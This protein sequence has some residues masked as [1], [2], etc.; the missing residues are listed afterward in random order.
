[1]MRTLSTRLTLVLGVLLALMSVVCVIVTVHAMNRHM[2]AVDQALHR[3]LAG[4]VLRAHLPEIRASLATGQEMP[5]FRQ[6]MTINPNAEFYLLDAGGRVMS[7]IVPEGRKV[8]ERVA[9]APIVQLLSGMPL[10]ILGED[11][12]EPRSRRVF[13]AAAVEY[14]GIGAGYVYVVLGGDAYRSAAGLFEASHIV[15]L[16]LTSLVVAS[17][18]AFIAGAVAFRMLS[19][20]LARLAAAMHAFDAAGFRNAPTLREARADGD[21]IDDLSR[22]YSAMAGRIAAQFAE[23]Q[24]ADGSRRELLT[25]ISHDLRTPLATMQAYLE[26]MALKADSLDAPT[27]ASYLA[28]ALTFSRRLDRLTADLFELATL[29]LHEAPFRPERFALAELV[30]DIGQRFGLQAKAKGVVIDVSA[31]APGPVIEAD[32]GLIERL[33]ANLI[34]NAIKFTPSG[35]RITLVVDETAGGSR[36]LVEDTGIGIPIEAIERVFDQF[37]RASGPANGVEGTGLGLAIAKRIV[38]L[39]GGQISAERRADVGTRMVVQ[40]PRRR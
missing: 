36:V 37:Y 16:A 38:E 31:A 7:H 24:R 19:G 3:Q 29:D 40:I 34:D 23:L 22:V 27:R 32:I 2:Q 39:H 5:V 10:P 11:P 25:H 21:D 6:L 12:R 8:M 26:T 28:A 15:R 20:R 4:E 14:D 9:V 33:L 1:M 35:G 13:S 18:A 30:Q 17:L